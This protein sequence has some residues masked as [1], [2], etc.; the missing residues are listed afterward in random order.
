MEFL[1]RILTKFEEKNKVSWT[2]SVDLSRKYAKKCAQEPLKFN[3][4]KFFMSIVDLDNKGQSGTL[5]RKVEK[6][7]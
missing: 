2:L 3:I 1:I 5:G 7:F 4:W 6:V